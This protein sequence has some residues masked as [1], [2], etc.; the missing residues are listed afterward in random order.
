MI[1]NDL[2]ISNDHK[3]TR[4]IFEFGALS[5]IMDIGRKWK[6]ISITFAVVTLAGDQLCP[7]CKS[8]FMAR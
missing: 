5:V 6:L 3:S 4:K 7:V 8:K 1:S 2:M